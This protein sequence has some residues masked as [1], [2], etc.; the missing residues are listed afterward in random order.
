MVLSKLKFYICFPNSNIFL[1]FSICTHHRK[2]QKASISPFWDCQFSWEILNIT[3]VC[4]T[5][6]KFS[7]KREIQC[8][9]QNYEIPYLYIFLKVPFKQNITYLEDKLSPFP[10]KGHFRSKGISWCLLLH[11]SDVIGGTIDVL[12]ASWCSSSH[13]FFIWSSEVMFRTPPEIW[14]RLYLPKFLLKVGNIRHSLTRDRK[15][16]AHHIC[17]TN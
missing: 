9:D 17:R 5:S 14:G 15:I 7:I 8:C 6:Y 13:L 10:Q 1:N 11:T 4:D 12:C 2:M 16:I 3:E